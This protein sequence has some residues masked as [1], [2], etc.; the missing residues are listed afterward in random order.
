MSGD[1]E[2]I[3]FGFVRTDKI[4][5]PNDN[6]P[7][8]DNAFAIAESIRVVNMLFQPLIVRRVKERHRKKHRKKWVTK[9]V[10][11]SGRDRFEA[12]S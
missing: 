2:P 7:D 9:I 1:E 4:V 6:G 10:L 5:L 3:E 12:L 11:V 8:H